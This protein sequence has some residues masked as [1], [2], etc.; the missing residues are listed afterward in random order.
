MYFVYLYCSTSVSLVN[1][2]HIYQISY[3]RSLRQCFQ[4][5]MDFYKNYTGDVNSLTMNVKVVTH[6]YVAI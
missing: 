4:E 5:F 1:N 6:F 2:K 3:Q